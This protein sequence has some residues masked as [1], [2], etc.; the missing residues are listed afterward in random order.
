MD[1][2]AA[3]K[4]RAAIGL[5]SEEGSEGVFIFK[6][7]FLKSRTVCRTSLR[8]D[9]ETATAWGGVDILEGVC[10]TIDELVRVVNEKFYIKFQRPDC[11]SCAL[12]PGGF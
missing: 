4:A 9:F 5:M 2:W 8:E 1:G 10:V 11:M 3:S 12:L 7:T 6:G